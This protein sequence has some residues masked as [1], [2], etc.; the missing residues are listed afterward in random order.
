MTRFTRFAFTPLAATAALVVA[1]SAYAGPP[2]LCHPYNIGSAQSLPW[3]GASSWFDGDPS[4]QVQN[5]IADT[6]ALLTPATPV[7]VRMETLRRAA[8]Y[9]STDATLAGRLLDRFVARAEAPKG[10]PDALLWLD[11]AY[12]AGAYREMS[13]LTQDS[14]W[15]ARAPGLKRALGTKKDTDF[16]ARSV[17]ARPDDPG[18]RF[19]AAVIVS[20]SDRQAYLEHAAK[21]RAGAPRDPLIAKNLD[22]VGQ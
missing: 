2:L 14:R 4:Y 3:S 10:Q 13:M 11:A 21:A 6:E 18:I 5:V 19:A 1:S 15:A 20:D 22:H 16:I 8:I 9:A 17:A 12:L 7:I